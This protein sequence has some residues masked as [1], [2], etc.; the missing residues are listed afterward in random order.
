V[1]ACPAK[2]VDSTRLGTRRRRRYNILILPALLSIYTQKAPLSGTRRVSYAAWVLGRGTFSRLDVVSTMS[3]IQNRRLEKIIN[4]HR[5]YNSRAYPLFAHLQLHA[6]ISAL[7]PERERVSGFTPHC[8]Q[9]SY[10]PFNATLYHARLIYISVIADT[11]QFTPS[12]HTSRFSRFA[13]THSRGGSSYFLVN[14]P[15]AFF[16]TFRRPWFPFHAD[17]YAYTYIH[18]YTRASAGQ[19]DVWC[20]CRCVCM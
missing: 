2:Y 18:I 4:Q 16:E 15:G 19:V 1:R 9:C 3:C 5:A 13:P 11:S 17:L 20:V 12:I 6:H 14:V 7:V 10:M 8:S